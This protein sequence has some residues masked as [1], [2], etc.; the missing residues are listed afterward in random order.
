M[1]GHTTSM[2]MGQSPFNR[3]LSEAWKLI[4]LREVSWLKGKERRGRWGKC[5]SVVPKVKGSCPPP[6]LFF[7]VDTHNITPDQSRHTWLGKPRV[8][9]RGKGSIGW[10]NGCLGCIPDQTCI[11]QVFNTDLTI[12]KSLYSSQ[13]D[14]TMEK[15]YVTLT[16][17]CY[18]IHNFTDKA[19]KFFH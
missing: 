3:R 18:H 7:G 19:L 12:T 6:L 16:K 1:K 15:G 17:V 13:S 11:H 9:L 10:A 8:F 2:S 5:R 4:L 14:H